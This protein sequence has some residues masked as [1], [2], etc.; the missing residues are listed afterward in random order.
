MLITLGRI[1][2]AAI[3]VLTAGSS[4]ALAWGCEGHQ[5]VAIVAER[6]LGTATMRA[7]S[8][9]LAASPIDRTLARYCGHDPDL[10]ADVSTWADDER[11]VDPSTAG[12]HFINLP[13]VAGAAPIDYRKYCAG[14]N[15]V[16]EA[17]VAQYHTLTTSSDPRARANALRF[18]IHFV[19]DLHQPLH[20]ITNGDRGG[21][22]LAIA[23]PGEP[24]REQENHNFTPNLHRV[25]DV[26][27]IARFMKARG[28][29]D[30]RA[31]AT[32]V[33]GSTPSASLA[34]PHAP[35][36]TDVSSWARESYA[37][38]QTVA[39]GKLPVNVP[40]QPAAANPLRSCDDNNHIG[41][42]LASLHETV[43][44]AYE[45]AAVPVIVSQMRL[46]GERLASILKAA[47]PAS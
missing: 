32:Y 33:A 43:T 14:G 1:M 4:R 28:L 44:S 42:R 37:L 6:L 22:C 7:V 47:F 17:I 8:A 25:W 24:V 3:V 46:A 31:L 21:N 18:I 40:T 5:T 13:R 15:C 27:I 38:A 36:A 11:S 12:W 34:A 39:Y 10:L 29:R 26:D 35:T 2:L 45:Q 9:V 23:V 41:Q 19:G 30:A 20:A 16:I